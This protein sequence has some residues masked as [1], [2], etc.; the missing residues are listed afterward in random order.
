MA[1]IR[2]KDTRPEILVR[3]AVHAAG[4]RF[5][6]HS[7]KLPG[8]PDLVFRRHRVAAFVH[9]CFWHGHGCRV[10]HIPKTNTDYWLAKIAR[11]SQRDESNIT[12]LDQAGWHVVVLWECGIPDGIQELIGILQR[13]R[14][15]VTISR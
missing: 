14:N 11:N 3:R 12:L 1:A 7:K 15:K 5:R 6:L 8:S 2:S 13:S 4:F 10:Q 9:G